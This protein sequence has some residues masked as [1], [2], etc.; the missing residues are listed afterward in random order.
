MSRFEGEALAFLSPEQMA[1]LGEDFSALLPKG[2]HR[3]TFAV[4]AF[5]RSDMFEVYISP[6]G[7]IVGLV[8]ADR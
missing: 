8:D 7:K 4:W 5:P 6:E 1:V 3:V 2:G